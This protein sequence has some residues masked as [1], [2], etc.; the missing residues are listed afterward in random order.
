MEWFDVRSVATLFG[1]QPSTVRSWINKGHLAA[2][3]KPSSFLNADGHRQR[4]SKYYISRLDLEEFL[5]GRWRSAMPGHLRVTIENLIMLG[6]ESGDF[7]V[8]VQ[9]EQPV[10]ADRRRMTLDMLK[11]VQDLRRRRG[12]MPANVHPRRI[13]AY[14]N[15]T[16]HTDPVQLEMFADE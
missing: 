4:S 16:P 7:V 13:R 6:Q 10:H 1:V 14:L 11:R 2:V 3:Q 5:I 12:L 8:D 15:D 9:P